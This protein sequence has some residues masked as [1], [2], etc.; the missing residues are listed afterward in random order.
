MRR[1]AVPQAFPE[2][3]SCGDAPAQGTCPPIRT[4][5]YLFVYPADATDWLPVPL[6]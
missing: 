6:C 4:T 5:V 3:V 2:L 1:E